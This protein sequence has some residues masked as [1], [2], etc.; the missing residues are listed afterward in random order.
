[1]ERVIVVNKQETKTEL[2]LNLKVP[3]H[4]AMR[5]TTLAKTKGYST[6]EAYLRDVLEDIAN[7]QFQLDHVKLLDEVCQKTNEVLQQFIPEYQKA[8]QLLYAKLEEQERKDYED[9]LKSEFGEDANV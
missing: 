8:R 7:D 6:R 5:L 4:V 1:M 2:R 3:K 9:W